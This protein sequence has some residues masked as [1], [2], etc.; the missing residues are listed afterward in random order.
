M[1]DNLLK[2]ATDQEPQIITEPE[3]LPELGSYKTTTPEEPAD[4]FPTAAQ[5]REAT[6]RVIRKECQA[7]LTKIAEAIKES[8]SQGA[9][10]LKLDG[11]VNS[12]GVWFLKK[13]GYEIGG[14]SD[15]TYIFW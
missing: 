1:S 2:P 11:P 10:W 14:N 8:R 6:E 12:A 5:S 7:E 15:H 4:A 9:T 13:L 3:P